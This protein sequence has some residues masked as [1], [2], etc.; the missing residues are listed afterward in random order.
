MV[1]S[2]NRIEHLEHQLTG[3]KQAVA[4][5]R[6]IGQIA[7]EVCGSD[8]VDEINRRVLAMCLQ[9]FAA[10]QGTIHLLCPCDREAVLR[11]EV[12]AKTAVRVRK[13]SGVLPARLGIG[14]TG[15]V[16]KYQKPLLSNDLSCDPRFPGAGS[17]A[18]QI[19][20]V[21]AVPLRTHNGLVGILTL[22]NKRAAGGFD[23]ED[24]RVLAIIGGYSAQMIENAQL[25]EKER[26]RDEELRAAAVIQR[27]LLPRC[28]PCVDG[29]EACGFSL[30]AHEVGGDY[31]DWAPLP[32]GRLGCVLADVSGKGFASAILMAQLQAA[33]S[34]QLQVDASPA[35]ALDGI[36]RFLA[37]T[38]ENDRFVTMFYGVADPRNNQL[39]WASAGHYPP[40]MLRENGELVRL[41]LGGMVLSR[42]SR[43]PY[44]TYSTPFAPG[45]TLMVY[46]D[47]VI[48]AQSPD[49]RE[50]G[51]ERLHELVRRSAG[52]R[53]REI[54]EDLRQVLRMHIGDAEQF[55][56]ITVLVLSRA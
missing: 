18:P 53:P 52:R 41:E 47:G 55:D 51:T 14:L 45:D 35:A 5:L 38:M 48:D 6:L 13:D 10:E 19:R 4:E 29:L 54:G 9:H 42:L 27:G 39:T 26:Q 33:F 28:P 17:D 37:Q 3:L 31:F 34:A 25:H 56:D 1:E 46:S 21:L 50:W 7:Q 8:S 12:R 30:P 49:G 24:Q 22:F 11:T 23:D 16:A 2:S 32:G 43:R 44:V 15:W 40:W 36:N 20:S